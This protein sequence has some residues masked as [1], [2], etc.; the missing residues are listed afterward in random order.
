MTKLFALEGDEYKEVDAFLQPEVDEIVKTRLDRERGKF[1]DYDDL[2]QKAESVET[3]KS[4]FEE[5]LKGADAEKSEL[6]KKLAQ[7]N[8]ET[9][10]VKIVNEFKLSDDLSEFVTG[11]N[12]DEMRKRAEKLSKT[13]GPGKVTIEKTP[14][15]NEKQS[16]SKETARKLFRQNS[17]D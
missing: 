7:A 16:S 17:D 14:K 10:K 12:A 2:K 3:V 4:E 15:P 6:E 11:E 9:E 13:A 8:L 1:S 5:K